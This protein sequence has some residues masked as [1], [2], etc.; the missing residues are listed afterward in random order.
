MG[1]LVAG[2]FEL[3]FEILVANRKTAPYALGLVVL[4]VGFGVYYFIGV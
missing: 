3:I 4:L 1:E 2:F